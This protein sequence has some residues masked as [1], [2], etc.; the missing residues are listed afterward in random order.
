MDV[1]GSVAATWLHSSDRPIKPIAPSSRSPHPPNK[2]ASPTAM[3]QGKQS[4]AP[5][6]PH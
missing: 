2:P 3:R 6:N 4:V 5:L 1:L